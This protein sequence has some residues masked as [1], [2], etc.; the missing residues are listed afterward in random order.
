MPRTARLD[1]PDLLQHVIVRGVNRCAVFVDDDDRRKFLNRFSQLLIET[2]TDCYA[3]ALMSNHLHL[4]VRPRR[5]LAHL[6]RRLL[7]GYAIYFNRRHDRCGHLFQDRYKSLVCEE[8]SYLLELVRYIHLNPLRAGLIKNLSDL[9]DYPWTGH[10]ILMMQDE[11]PGQMVDEVLSLF[12]S[13]RERALQKYRAFIA[14][15][16]GMELRDDLIGKRA[17]EQDRQ[18]FRILGDDAFVERLLE[19]GGKSPRLGRSVPLEDLVQRVCKY[20][21]VDL[22]EIRRNIRTKRIAGARS[23]I[24]YWA[25]REEGYSGVKVGDYINLS[26]SGVSRAVLRGAEMVREDAS[27]MELVNK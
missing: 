1:Y 15:G 9:D 10:R 13:S 14:D 2:Q 19:R 21:D 5:S 11:F 16:C 23:L 18:D 12:A 4:L 24:C 6:M 27:L 7:T 20:L 3:W 17:D 25:I 26:R 22:G 8:D